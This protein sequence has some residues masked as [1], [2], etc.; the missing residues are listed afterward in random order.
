MKTNKFNNPNSPENL[1]APWIN[2]NT[3]R[4]F[5]YGNGDTQAFGRIL[6]LHILGLADSH[7]KLIEMYNWLSTNEA[8]EFL[9]SEQCDPSGEWIL[10]AYYE[11]K[12]PIDRYEDSG[13]K[14][15][16]DFVKN[17]I[18]SY[19]ENWEPLKYELE[20]R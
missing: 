12:A 6:L 19:Y 20:L 4:F 14:V 10:N 1:L 17:V 11:M 8:R 7:N 16:D 3:R 13:K 5:E 2:A 15:T 18:D 9:W